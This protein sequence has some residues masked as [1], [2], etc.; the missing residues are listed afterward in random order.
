MTRSAAIA[1]AF[2]TIVASRAV[3][4]A[5]DAD[6]LLYQKRF[7][8]PGGRV[9]DTGNG[10]VSHS[11]GQG[12]GLLLAAHY[13]D[14]A[15]FTRIWAW[16][17]ANLQVRD[18]HLLAWRWL[19]LAE[20]DS[21]ARVPD[22][23]NATDG[24]LLVAWA[25]ARAGRLWNEP[26]YRDAARALCADIRS[27]LVMHS[28]FG[29]VLL[30]GEAGFAK[31]DATLINLSYWVF[32]AL[33]ELGRVDP[34]SEWQNLIDSGGVLL[35]AARFGRW[36]LPPDWLELSSPLKP[37]TGFKPRFGYDALRIP[38]YL[39]WAKLA[40]AQNLT[41]F[42][43]FWSYFNGA[44][45]TPAWTLFTDDSIDSFD[46]SPGVHAVIAL[47]AQHGVAPPGHARIYHAPRLEDSQDYYSAS[48][49]LLAK[50]AALESRA[51]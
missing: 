47:A 5:P 7:V 33:Q 31:A 30:P 49:L 10:G 14:R 8:D 32:P 46:A 42:N 41:A 23:N 36:Q 37:A 24:D 19:P 51:R 11:E 45:F 28:D 13:G 17:R 16:T 27:K 18:D 43:G 26:Q 1:A 29:P 40:T 3:Q 6:W 21:A 34:S 2:L 35:Q 12:T 39:T 48:L 15:A 9:I 38:L 44:R 22:R 25:L 4:A 20:G 50:M